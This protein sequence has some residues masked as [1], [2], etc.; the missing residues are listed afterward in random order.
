MTTVIEEIGWSALNGMEFE[1]L[2]K[3]KEKFQNILYERQKGKQ[4]LMQHIIWIQ[5]QLKTYEYLTDE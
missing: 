5:Q 1:D 4:D 3:L 2:L